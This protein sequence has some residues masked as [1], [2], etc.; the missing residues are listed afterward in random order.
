MLRS[1]NSGWRGQ[2]KG[3]VSHAQHG[4]YDEKHYM[5]GKVLA[6]IGVAALVLAWCALDSW[7]LTV[8]KTLFEMQVAESP[9][10]HG[11]V[12]FFNS[13]MLITFLEFAFTGVVL[14]IVWW[15]FSENPR[16][17][18]SRLRASAPAPW[19][20][21]IATFSFSTFWLQSLMMPSS[22]LSLSFFAMSRA[23]EVPGA[24][25]LRSMAFA[26]PYGGHASRTVALMTVANLCLYYSYVQM[27]GCLCI[28]SGHGIFLEGFA[29]YVV[30]GLLLLAPAIH[31]NCQEVLLVH[32]NIPPTLLLAVQNLAA[33]VLL[34]PLMLLP[35]A[36]A[37]AITLLE[38]PEVSLLTL[39]LCVQVAAASAVS[40]A[41]VYSLG[42]FWAVALRGMRV[43]YWWSCQLLT[44]YVSTNTF[45]SV[46][47]PRVSLWSLI[48]LCG[49]FC[50]LGAIATDGRY[51]LPRT[52]SKKEAITV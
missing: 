37:G 40:L 14:T 11:K 21:L 43:A 13:P 41:L 31:A 36:R 19:P 22:V 39:W 16:Q 15:A 17:D 20:L 25:F 4:P 28:W 6:I 33:T 10:K 35:Q 48:M 32:H 44:F 12:K 46:A 47:H 3:A 8:T 30:Y 7:N 52:T 45:L 24:A 23:A 42:S 2:S 34:M 29:L 49:F 27:E 18:L 38:Y 1:S 50:V 5:V 9:T 26:V 51:P